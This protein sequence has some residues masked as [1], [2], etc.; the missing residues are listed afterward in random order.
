MANR[1]SDA[2][3]CRVCV[4]C[5]DKAECLKSFM[6]KISRVYVAECETMKCPALEIHLLATYVQ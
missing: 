4:F 5:I 1:K 3:L 2:T 6:V